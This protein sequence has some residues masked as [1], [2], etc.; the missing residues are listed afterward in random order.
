MNR[1]HDK[2]PFFLSLALAALC[3]GAAFA[4]EQEAQA[5]GDD[6]AYE[7]IKLFAET[8]LH[9]KRHYVEEKSYEEIVHGGLRGLLQSLDPHSDFLDAAAYRAMRE[10]AASKFGG[11]G[12]TVGLRNGALIV[13][14]PMEGTP[15]FE[16]GILAGDII[17][18]VDGE[19]S[20]GMSLR[21]AVGKLRGPKG[22]PVH[23]AVQRVDEADAREYTLVREEIEIESV[24]GARLVRDRIG[25]VRL[26]Q[27][28]RPTA[29]AL[30]EALEA[31]VDQGLQALVLDLRNNQGGLLEMSVDVAQLFLERDAVIVATRGR[32]GVHDEVEKV[33]GGETRYLTVPMVAL[34]NGGTASAA[35]IV[36]GALQDHGRAIL[37]GETT[38]GK[39]SVQS[40]I[41]LEADEEVAI[42][43]TIGQY[44]TPAGRAIHGTGIDPCIEMTLPARQWRDIVIRQRHR[45]NPDHYSEE[46]MREYEDVM[47]PPLERALDI[48]QGV[49]LFRSS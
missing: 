30:R 8:L 1:K 47:D 6:L 42:R 13:I 21:D 4:G 40:L 43:L 36:A 11:I 38:F 37:I 29:A 27:F 9:V 3:A 16:A 31:L 7:K 49:L 45:E 25:Y 23:I 26:T 33:A 20:D 22:E 28:S 39:A 35:E 2:V 48:L 15:A 10:N 34:V 18:K 5:G 14:A 46:E 41:Q 19:K 17:V 24:K 44:Y 32:E 12:I